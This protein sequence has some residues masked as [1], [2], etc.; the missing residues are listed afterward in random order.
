MV[1]TNNNLSSI[2]AVDIGSSTTRALLF[3]IVNTKY[4]FIAE[5]SAP[6]TA[7]SPFFDIAECVWHAIEDLQDKTGRMM[8]S[9]AEG[10]IIP[11]TMDNNGVDAMVATISAG[12]PIRVVTVGL[13]Q[14]VS[15]STANQL[16]STIN[17]QVVEEISLNDRRQDQDRI[18]LLLKTRPDLIII[19]GGTN[20][21]ASKSILN[22]IEV[23][24]LA[25]YLTKDDQKTHI[26]YVGNE[27]LQ[28]D[29]KDD[30][31]KISNLH[32]A[33][34]IQPSL[35]QKQMYPAQKELAEIFKMIRRKQIGGMSEVLTWTD[36][37]MTATATAFSRMIRFLSRKYEPDKGVLGIDIG[38]RN[39][40]ITASFEGEETLRVLPNLG[41]GAGCQRILKHVQVSDITRWLPLKI[42]D[43][44]VRDYVNNK[45]IYPDSLPATQEEIAIEHAV[46]REILRATVK[47][48]L[49]KIPEAFQKGSLLPSVE[50][51]IGSGSVITQ[52]PKRTQS[53]LILLDGLQPAGV[54]TIALDQ[55]GLLP[56]LGIISDINPLLTVQ[57]IETST[58]L[59]LGTVI[60]PYGNAR[61]GTPILRMRI[62]RQNG[63]KTTRDIKY[64]TLSV[65]PTSVGEQVTLHLRPLHGFDIGMGGPGKAGKVSAVGGS[66]GIIIDARGRPLRFSPDPEKNRK[67]AKKWIT[68]LEKFA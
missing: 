66:L 58:F 18:N 16:A 13:L 5:G 29:V 56:S 47:D 24:G 23:V 48:I 44:F 27:E 10:L 64:G 45:S 8:I 21:G 59:N 40:T 50:P 41:I 37:N 2:L 15:I 1:N 49:P 51:I 38:S 9:D 52:A 7:G 14:D 42:P 3:D 26:L 65:L 32:I 30:L 43:S 57:V 25:G 34:N 33:P 61:L 53:L 62:T 17:A 35:N 19:S 60:A 46:A 63:E 11:S 12:K 55:N 28:E 68:S 67:R 22:L 4:R 54:T 20:G 39:T 36:G 31:G 6:S